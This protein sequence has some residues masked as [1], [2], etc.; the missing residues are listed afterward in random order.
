MNPE[1]GQHVKCFM[2]STMVLEGIVEDWTDAQVVLKSLDGESIMIVHRPVEDIMLTKVV[3]VPDEI[4]E[5]KSLKE[6]PPQETELK[7]RIAGKLREVLRSGEDAD[8][9]KMNL[10]QLREMV[11]E[12]EKLIITQKRTEHF[13]SAG[14]AKRAAPYSNP[15]GLPAQLPQFRQY[16][17]R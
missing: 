13:G 3:L 9:D 10:D 7:K 6:L 1:K 14:H 11:D 16:G 4:P 8:L 2:R 12:Q 17:R 5:E 15:L